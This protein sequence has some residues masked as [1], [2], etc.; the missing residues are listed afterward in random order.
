MTEPVP[1]NLADDLDKQMRVALSKVAAANGTSLGLLRVPLAAAALEVV[2]SELDR[3]RTDLEFQKETVRAAAIVITH[4]REVQVALSVLLRG[5]ARRAGEIRRALNM[6]SAALP[7]SCEELLPY[8]IEDAQTCDQQSIPGTDRCAQHTEDQL[9]A[10]L[11]IRHRALLDA[12][13][14]TSLPGRNEPSRYYAA[15]GEVH[16]LRRYRT[17][18]GDLAVQLHA[19]REQLADGAR[20]N[21]RLEDD[22]RA[23]RNAVRWL[24]RDVAFLTARMGTGQARVVEVD[25]DSPLGQRMAR[26]MAQSGVPTPG[27]GCGHDGMGRGWHASDCD[28]V[29]GTVTAIPDDAAARLAPFLDG[30]LSTAPKDLTGKELAEVV[31]NEIRNWAVTNPTSASVKLV[32][33]CH[34]ALGNYE[35]ATPQQIEEWLEHRELSTEGSKAELVARLRADDLHPAHSCGCCPRVPRSRCESWCPRSFATEAPVE[36]T[37]GDQATGAPRELDDGPEEEPFLIVAHPYVAT[38]L[39][40]ECGQNRAAHKSEWITVQ[41]APAAVREALD[42]VGAVWSEVLHADGVDLNAAYRFNGKPLLWDDINCLTDVGRAVMDHLDRAST[43]TQS[44]V[45]ERQR[46]DDAADAELQ[47]TLVLKGPLVPPPT[48]GEDPTLTGLRAKLRGMVAEL[49]SHTPPG[50]A[51]L[52]TEIAYDNGFRDS[53]IQ[54]GNDLEALLDEHDMPQASSTPAPAPPAGGGQQ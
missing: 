13:G 11:D 20:L 18:Q 17:R 22:N 16:E 6:C 32:E 25:A 3:A 50:D 46:A 34:E 53:Q 9:R 48:V 38:E 40:H 5:M 24:E 45:S 12:L 37:A 8:D 47:D 33:F 31:V 28:W 42:R 43:V 49:R 39:C 15:I 14:V 4:Q 2:E 36:P 44:A 29:K 52:P 23:L 10:N 41:W 27:C 7:N 1:A 21:R 51:W 30:L 26:D 35:R 54:A 19:V